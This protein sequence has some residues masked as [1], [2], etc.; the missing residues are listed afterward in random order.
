MV[1]ADIFLLLP[2]A[3]AQFSIFPSPYLFFLHLSF[4]T[5]FLSF[6]PFSVTFSSSSSFVFTSFVSPSITLC[7]FLPFSLV[8]LFFSLPF[9]LCHL[10]L[11]FFLPLLLSLSLCVGIYREKKEREGYNPVQSW[12]RGCSVVGR[13]LGSCP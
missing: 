5:I 6:L 1:V 7:F 9:T 2:C 4:L 12:H 8:S 11:K 10:L 3:M 13:P